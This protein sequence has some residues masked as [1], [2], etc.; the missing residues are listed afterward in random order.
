MRRS[1]AQLLL[2]LLLLLLLLLR[3]R[4]RGSGFRIGR[5]FHLRI[6]SDAFISAICPHFRVLWSSA[7]CM[8]AYYKDL[9]YYYPC[10]CLSLRKAI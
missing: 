8:L 6:G 2:S 7:L 4:Q 9:L 1:K 5:H 3:H 10:P